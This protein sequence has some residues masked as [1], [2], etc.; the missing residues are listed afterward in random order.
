MSASDVR[1]MPLTWFRRASSDRRSFVPHLL[2]TFVID[3]SP[4][5]RRCGLHQ[6]SLCRC[7]IKHEPRHEG[8]C[9]AIGLAFGMGPVRPEHDSLSTVNGESALA[10]LTTWMYRG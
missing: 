10:R 5:T 9:T 2:L 3:I 7:I 6:Y 4:D 8:L 1:R